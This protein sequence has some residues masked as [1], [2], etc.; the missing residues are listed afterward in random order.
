MSSQRKARQWQ[1][2]HFGSSQLP[3][4]LN[5]VSSRNVLGA[6]FTHRFL[7]T[8]ILQQHILHLGFVHQLSVQLNSKVF[9][10]STF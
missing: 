1:L 6:I 5:S 3:N 4:G 10:Q 8:T 7:L 9:H 2:R